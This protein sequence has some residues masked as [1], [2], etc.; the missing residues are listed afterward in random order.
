MLWD[1]LY[2]NTLL[3]SHSS[4]KEIRMESTEDNSILNSAIDKKLYLLDEAFDL[5]IAHKC[6]L[7]MQL[8]PDGLSCA[9]LDKE[10]NKY[11]ALAYWPCGDHPAE[12][13]Y[14]GAFAETYKENELLQ[15]QYGSVF[16]M[17]NA[18]RSTLV[19]DELFKAGQEKGYYEFNNGPSHQKHVHYSHV[20]QAGVYLM[21]GVPTYITD[22]VISNYPNVRF[23]HQ[24]N[25]LLSSY[26]PGE[27]KG[28]IIHIHS[29]RSFYDLL[30]I[31][32]GEL[33]MYNSFE[34]QSHE[35]LNFYVMYSMDK[36]GIGRQ[37]SKLNISG[38]F[39]EHD[40]MLEKFQQY[41]GRVEPVR[42][43]KDFLYSYMLDELPQH[44]FALL[45]ELYHCG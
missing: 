32:D 3:P 27:E 44:R 16:F 34:P 4:P 8:S 11:V 36:L 28:E 20:E 43:S 26:L 23:F 7:S 19:P 10:L 38:Y 30:F 29:N 24:A 15:A 21:Y 14:C 9:I 35:D 42:H 41:V 25:P 12:Q 17:F 18:A 37:Q 33:L 6:H 31:R 1:F 2:L 40:P 5:S 13:G 22:Q 45:F 39:D